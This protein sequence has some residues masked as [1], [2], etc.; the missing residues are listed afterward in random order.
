MRSVNTERDSEGL[1]IALRE[2]FEE[3]FVRALTDHTLETAD[4]FT[5][6][7]LEDNTPVRT[8]S[9]GYYTQSEYLLSLATAI[10][11]GVN[12]DAT[13][14][15]RD[16]VAGLQALK[17]ARAKFE[18]DHPACSCGA[19]QHNRYIHACRRCGA[20]FQGSRD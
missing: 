3:A 13:Q 5:L 4:E 8:L 15:T 6:A 1:E 12:F 10:D 16:D 9:P 7:R 14:V 2:I 19:R 11:C 17:R 20:K 18:A